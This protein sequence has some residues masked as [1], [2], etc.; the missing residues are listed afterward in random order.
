MTTTAEYTTSPGWDRPDVHEPP[1]RVLRHVEVGLTDHHE[2]V[3]G[4]QALPLQVAIGRQFGRG[5]LVRTR[6]FKQDSPASLSRPALP[7]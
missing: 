4:P 2:P 1:G 3:P 7:H 5:T 6:V